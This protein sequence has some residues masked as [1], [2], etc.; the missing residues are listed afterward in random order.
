[1]NYENLRAYIT[2]NERDPLATMDTI[3]VR[4]DEGGDAWGSVMSLPLG[5]ADKVIKLLY[6]L[7]SSRLTG[8][9]TCNLLQDRGV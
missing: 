3:G 2:R 6:E 8:L 9:E 7:T 4:W 5:S 1:M